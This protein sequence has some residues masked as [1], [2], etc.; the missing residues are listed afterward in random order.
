MKFCQSR[1]IYTEKE[2][3]VTGQIKNCNGYIVLVTCLL[4]NM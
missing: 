1:I 2:T 3:A 4:K